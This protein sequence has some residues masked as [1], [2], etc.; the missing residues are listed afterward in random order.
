MKHDWQSVP[1][2]AGIAARP[3]DARGF[4]ITFVTLIQ[5]DGRPDFTT[6]DGG[7]IMRCIYE[8]LCGLCGQDLGQGQPVAFIGGPISCSGGN[9][10]DPPMHPECAKYAMQV[11]PHIAIDTS[12]YAKPK[13]GEGRELFQGVSPD[14]PDKFGLYATDAFKVV[15]YMGQPMFSA[16]P[17]IEIIWSNE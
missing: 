8:D 6:V 15:N 2:P 5:S 10:L 14:R 17:P 12:R 1:M 9:F 11:C 7:K 3:K 16:N 13:E 4:P